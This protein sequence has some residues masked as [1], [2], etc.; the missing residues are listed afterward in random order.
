MSKNSTLKNIVL[1][2]G[3]AGL[4]TTTSCNSCNENRNIDSKLNQKIISLTVDENSRSEYKGIVHSL[5][6][7]GM[8]SETVFSVSKENYHSTNT[9]FSINKKEF[10][11]N[12]AKYELISVTHD[13][14]KIKYVPTK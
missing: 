9:Y 13:T 3:F 8:P 12:G 4:L 7:N 14:L 11:F 2:I 5:R 1:A 10:E 6:Y